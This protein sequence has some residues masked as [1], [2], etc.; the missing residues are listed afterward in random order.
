M[1]ARA[2]VLA[3]A[4][5]LVQIACLGCSCGAQAHTVP[6]D[7]W[8]P[9]GG[10]GTQCVA[11]SL[12]AANA[13]GLLIPNATCPTA[14][15]DAICSAA[16]QG[17]AV[18]GRV[19]SACISGHCG[20][21]SPCWSDRV[22]MCSCGGDTCAVGQLCVV[23]STGAAS[24]Q[25]PCL[26]ERLPAHACGPSRDLPAATPIAGPLPVFANASRSCR[27]WAQT[28]APPGTTAV[29]TSALALDGP[30]CGMGDVCSPSPGPSH[31]EPICTCGGATCG[32]SEVC[33][34]NEIGG[35]PSPHCAPACW[36]VPPP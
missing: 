14:A 21:G 25:D 34:T 11:G 26:R 1:R 23:D 20:W 33:V 28:F 3:F 18:A 35:D 29:A 30:H 4:S 36:P 13:V 31:P 9:D 6:I 15:G 17:Y 24:C 8:L 19:R 5:G 12:A 7:A 27:M 22:D 32:P 2:S 10:P 16:L